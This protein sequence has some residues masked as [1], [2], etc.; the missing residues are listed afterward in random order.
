MWSGDGRVRGGD[1]LFPSRGCFEFVQESLY[2]IRILHRNK[3]RA[4]TVALGGEVGLR[5]CLRREMRVRA[6]TRKGW[7][8]SGDAFDSLVTARPCFES[9]RH[10]LATTGNATERALIYTLQFRSVPLPIRVEVSSI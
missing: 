6:V 3:V 5:P 10:V 1:S 2:A 9:T 7:M 4:E 8:G